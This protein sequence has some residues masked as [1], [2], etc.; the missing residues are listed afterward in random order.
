MNESIPAARGVEASESDKK[1]FVE[2][3]FGS[4]KTL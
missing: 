1:A 4:L 3:L 2:R